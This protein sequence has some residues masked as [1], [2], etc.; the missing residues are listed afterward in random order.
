MM[1]ANEPAWPELFR[2]HRDWF[3]KQIR[4]RGPLQQHVVPLS[5]D[6]N[7]VAQ[8]N[9]ENVSPDFDSHPNGL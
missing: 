1:D 8:I 4:I 9:K 2:H 3:M 6:R 5:Q 7:N